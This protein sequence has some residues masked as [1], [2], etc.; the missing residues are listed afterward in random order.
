MRMK[1]HYGVLL[2][3]MSFLQT[4]FAQSHEHHERKLIKHLLGDYEPLER[5][6]AKD[7][8]VVD[9]KYDLKLIKISNLCLW[10]L[11]KISISVVKSPTDI[12]SNSHDLKSTPTDSF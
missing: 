5:P 9:L 11:F 7:D 8:D 3:A 6:V 10:E 2:L 1:L 12:P 4:I